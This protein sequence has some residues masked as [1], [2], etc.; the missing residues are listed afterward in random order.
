MLTYSLHFLPFSAERDR[1]FVI[2]AQVETME[3]SYGPS[4]SPYS[5]DDLLDLIEAAAKAPTNVIRVLLFRSERVGYYWY[6]RRPNNV[7]F[8]LDLFITQPYRGLG[9]GGFVLH[10]LL[11]EARST[12]CTTAKLAV[13]ANNARARALYAAAGFKQ[14]DTEVRGNI[15][16][17]EMSVDL[18]RPNLST[19]FSSNGEA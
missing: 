5:K 3:M 18:T 10:T 4:S 2:S 14:V 16:W 11:D 19:H 1:D 15:P 7:A 12:G 13:S 8:I 9:F 17:L 6:Q